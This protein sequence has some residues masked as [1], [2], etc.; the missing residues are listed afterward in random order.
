MSE[1]K[2][3]MTNP[4]QQIVMRELPRTQTTNPIYVKEYGGPYPTAYYET[5]ITRIEC[6]GSDPAL[7]TATRVKTF[8]KQSCYKF[9][10]KKCG[11][12]GGEG[13]TPNDAARLWNKTFA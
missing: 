8:L 12:E 4:V 2:N 6:C 7:F 11:R 3:D 5:H 13:V 9:S 1:A 10:C